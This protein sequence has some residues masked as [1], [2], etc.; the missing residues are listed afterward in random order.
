MCIQITCEV[1]VV[2]NKDH[3]VNTK[4]KQP[5][6][7]LFN[8]PIPSFNC[9]VKEHS[10]ACLFCEADAFKVFFHCLVKHLDLL[11]GIRNLYVVINIAQIAV[12][13][14]RKKTVLPVFKSLSF[15]CH[16]GINWNQ[17]CGG[18]GAYWSYCGMTGILSVCVGILVN[19]NISRASTASSN[20]I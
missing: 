13:V 6:W 9:R 16:S 20:V 18:G 17:S 5:M 7:L 3:K 11:I 8:D 19:N 15:F 4:S 14:F 10:F 1:W 2:T 12:S